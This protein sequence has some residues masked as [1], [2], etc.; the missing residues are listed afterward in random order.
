[1]SLI[2][3]LEPR[4]GRYAVPHLTLGLILFQVAV[5]VVAQGEMAK[6]EMA[7]AA[8]GM[9]R[10]TVLDRIALTPDKVLEGEVWRLV[11][12]V[13]TPPCLACG[14]NAEPGVAEPVGALALLERIVARHER[15]V[16]NG[17]SVLVLGQGG[18]AEQDCN[19]QRGRVDVNCLR[20][21]G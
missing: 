16:R 13:G 21:A 5:F 17:V 6:G 4:L 12:F 14:P 19:C 10:L 20:N 11:T 9:E 18:G 2:H 7:R 15:S 3:K 1:M 8:G